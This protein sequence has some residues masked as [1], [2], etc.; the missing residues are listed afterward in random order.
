MS[1]VGPMTYGLI[2]FATGGNHRLALVSTTVFFA[3]GLW[4][5][6]GVDERRG[7]AVAFGREPAGAVAR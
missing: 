1:V 6:R 7:R 3:L 2:G 5:L 4:I